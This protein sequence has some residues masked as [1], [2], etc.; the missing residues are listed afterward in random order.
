[1]EEVHCALRTCTQWSKPVSDDSVYLHYKITKNFC[2]ILKWCFR[3]AKGTV[4]FKK[5]M[6]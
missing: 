5:I 6:W 3:D 4:C 1:M 2:E